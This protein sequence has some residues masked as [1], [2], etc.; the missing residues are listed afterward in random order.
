MATEPPRRRSIS[1]ELTI[2]LVI[3]IMVISAIAI[4]G[5]YLNLS[6]RAEKLLQIK[7]DEYIE[8]TVDTLAVPMWD[9][10][11]ENVRDIGLSLARSDFLTGIR[12]VDAEGRVFL[13]HQ[14]TTDGP[15]IQR[16][17]PIEYNGERIGRVELSLSADRFMAGRRQMLLTTVGILLAVVVC[18]LVV[19]GLYTRM[20]LKKPLERLG[21]IVTAY[22]NGRYDTE[23]AEVPYA[24]FSPLFTVLQKMGHTITAQMG[25]LA[26]AEEKYRNIYENAVVGIYQEDPR[27]RFLNVNQTLARMLD[28]D[29]PSQVLAAYTNT[30][31]QLYVR[32]EDRDK[33]IR[34]CERLGRFTDMEIQWRRRDG[35][36]IWVSLSGRKVADG[37]GGLLYAE[38]IAADITEKKQYEQELSQ[39]RAHLEDL[40]EQRTRE[41]AAAKEEAERANAAKS[42][43]LANMSHEIRTP[44][45]AIIGLSNL[46]LGLDLPVRAES[47]MK[48]LQKSAHHLLDLIDNILDFSKIEAGQLTLETC[49]FSLRNLLDEL[50]AM[51]TVQTAEKGISMGHSIDPGIPPRLNGDPL[52]LRQILINLVNNA[53]KFTEEGEIAVRAVRAETAGDQVRLRFSV[54]DTGIGIPPGERSRLFTSFMQADSSTTRKFGG[55]G[56]GLAISRRLAEL[57]GGTIRIDSPGEAG[58]E[59]GTQF[60]FTAQFGLPDPSVAPCEVSAPGRHGAG[61]ASRLS[62]LRVLLAEDNRINQEVAMEMLRENG[63]AVAVAENGIEAV[64]AVRKV[65]YDAVLM[66]VQMPVM[67]GL[68]AARVI[69]EELGRETLPIIAITAHALDGDRKRCLAVGMNDYISKP[70]DPEKL[71]RTLRRW[72]DHDRDRPSPQRGGVSS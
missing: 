37:T 43:F 51:F 3:T 1:R 44:M 63:V 32:P 34:V 15:L 33:F 47:H 64:E 19:T 16:A 46:S 39:Y 52:R 62:G 69:R 4:S 67:D 49:D 65:R 8:F 36:I 38:G 12:V 35:E 50:V 22:A 55:T 72:V 23:W 5:I 56:L 66:D 60:S 9:I 61:P 25:E 29:E 18:L 28:Y 26:A 27:G 21:A 48:T 24:E 20:L 40:V 59:R 11:R 41:L 7:A 14:K 70:I 6:A 31:D 54:R 10:A 68:E 30:G 17:G 71:F 2:G 58:T 57:M 53:V 13:D 42:A 45:N